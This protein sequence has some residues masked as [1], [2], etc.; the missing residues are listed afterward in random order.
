MPRR[1]C[2]VLTGGGDECSD[3]KNPIGRPAVAG[4]SGNPHFH[5]DHIDTYLFSLTSCHDSARSKKLSNLFKYLGPRTGNPFFD[6]FHN[7]WIE[8]YTFSTRQLPPI[9]STLSLTVE[10]V[11]W[12][13]YCS[14]ISALLPNT[15]KSAQKE[16]S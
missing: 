4:L 8:D 10:R 14:P 5:R 15:R 13:L 9:E 1:V 12:H 11:L 6:F 3:F 7:K 2:P 16:F